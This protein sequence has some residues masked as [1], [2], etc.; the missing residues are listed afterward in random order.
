MYFL[1]INILEPL[2]S[3]V[4]KYQTEHYLNEHVNM[5][6]HRHVYFK[7]IYQWVCFPYNQGVRNMTTCFRA[8][9]LNIPILIFKEYTKTPGILVLPTHYQRMPS[10]MVTFPQSASH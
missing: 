8:H 9:I 1:N 2:T 6:D 5:H 3:R 4:A 7:T 10:Y